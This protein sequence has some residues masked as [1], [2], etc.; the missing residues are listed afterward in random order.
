MVCADKKTPKHYHS[1]CNDKCSVKNALCQRKT[2]IHK[3]LP[4]S[5]LES[6]CE[7]TFANVFSQRNH[8]INDHVYKTLAESKMYQNVGNHFG[9]LHCDKICNSKPAILL[10]VSDCSPMSP[11]SISNWT[12]ELMEEPIFEEIGGLLT[13]GTPS[14]PTKSKKQMEET[15]PSTDLPLLHITWSCTGRKNAYWL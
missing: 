4:F 13:M 3:D 5:C 8:Y 2:K 15:F 6:N 1:S 7:S 9:C 11:V 12:M 10:H 14:R